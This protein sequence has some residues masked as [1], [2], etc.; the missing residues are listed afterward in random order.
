[1]SPGSKSSDVYR[2]KVFVGVEIGPIE[3]LQELYQCLVRSSRSC[4]PI[5]YANAEVI[6]LVYTLIRF[7]S[8]S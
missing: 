1:M 8:F 3:G 2:L 4:R 6:R 5:L 7:L